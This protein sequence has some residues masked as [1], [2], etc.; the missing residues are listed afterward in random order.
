MARHPHDQPAVPERMRKPDGRDGRTGPD[1]APNG[2]AM[3]AISGVLGNPASSRRIP[4]LHPGGSSPLVH[5][6]LQGTESG[7]GHWQVSH[8]MTVGDLS[9]GL[10]WGPNAPFNHVNQLAAPSNDS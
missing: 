3:P 10:H 5:V 1:G 4:P 8:R 9:E 6:P 2:S 7:P